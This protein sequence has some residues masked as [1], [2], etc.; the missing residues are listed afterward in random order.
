MGLLTIPILKAQL[1][2]NIQW[3]AYCYKLH[4]GQNLDLC[5]GCNQV[6]YCPTPEVGVNLLA[7]TE[8]HV[9]H[10]KAGHKAEC[11]RFKAEAEAARMASIAAEREKKRAAMIK[12]VIAA[13]DAASGGV[14][15]YRGVVRKSTNV[16][17][18]R[19]NEID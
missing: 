5:G 17:K 16:L 12:A 2:G 19:M 3:C 6:G 11:G 15:K 1:E 4:P 10:W 18:Q 7:R 9:G 13:A 8:C 14:K